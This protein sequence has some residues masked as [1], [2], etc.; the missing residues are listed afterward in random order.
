MGIAEWRMTASSPAELARCLHA[1]N[2]KN[3]ESCAEY[4]P[5]LTTFETFLTPD[6]VSLGACEALDQFAKPRTPDCGLHGPAVARQREFGRLIQLQIA[7]D[8]QAEMVMLGIS[9][10]IAI[11]IEAEIGREIAARAPANSAECAP[12]QELARRKLHAHLSRTTSLSAG[13][14]PVKGALK[15]S[16]PLGKPGAAPPDRLAWIGCADAVSKELGDT[17]HNVMPALASAYV[18]EHH[19]I[20]GL[21]TEMA[22]RP[23]GYA[24]LVNYSVA[25]DDADLAHVRQPNMFSGG[26][27]HLFVSRSTTSTGDDLRGRTVRL[28]DTSCCAND[29]DAIACASCGSVGLPEAVVRQSVIGRSKV[30][31]KNIFIMSKP[32]ARRYTAPS[33][34]VIRAKN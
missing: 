32:D 9:N 8:R 12:I 17:P 24:A 19:R 14:A 15:L 25:F 7:P 5:V 3:D 27:R 4:A 6:M 26:W 16:A 34:D 21:P 30:S 20:M 13:T 33:C 2:L 18:S 22:V 10:D 31:V 28:R 1:F 29:A 11:D 23:P